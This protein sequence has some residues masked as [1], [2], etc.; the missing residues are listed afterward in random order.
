MSGASGFA[1]GLGKVSKAKK[2][3]RPQTTQIVVNEEECES[4]INKREASYDYD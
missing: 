1:Q 3:I 2:L 4:L